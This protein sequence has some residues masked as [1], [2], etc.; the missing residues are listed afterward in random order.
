MATLK[1]FEVLTNKFT[2]IHNLYKV[3]SLSLNKADIV[4]TL[5]VVAVV[6]EAVGTAS[7]AS[8]SEER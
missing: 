8:S 4:K 7:V 2:I 3:T 6:M 5:A 1:K